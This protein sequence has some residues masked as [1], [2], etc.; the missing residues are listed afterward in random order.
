MNKILTAHPSFQEMAIEISETNT[1]ISETNIDFGNFKDGWPEIFIQDVSN[2]IEGKS[3]TYL[4]D[5][6]SQ[7]K[8]FSNI[9]AIQAISW[10]YAERA[11]I[12]L[13]FFPVGTMERVDKEWQIATAK[14][15]LR[16][17]GATP[18]AIWGKCI[19]HFIDIHD[20]HERF[21]SSDTVAIKLH[22]AMDLLKES[23]KDKENIAIAFPDEGAKKRFAKDFQDFEIIECTKERQW[24]K[25][26]VCI[27]DGD[28]EWRNV[29]I[30][31]DLIQSWGT[32]IEC[33]SELRKQWANSVSAYAT[34][35]V[36]PENSH[37]KLASE[38]DQLIV[39]NT[40]PEQTEKL[41][42][43]DN[44]VVLN[45]KSIVEK[46]IKKEK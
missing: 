39:T 22:S 40:I 38:L 20:L 36:C 11:N 33:S 10:Y 3:V 45:I 1:E 27:K 18:A 4:W 30:V 34:H 32:I 19:F 31:D 43:I 13:P 21:Y 23:L 29:I 12:I 26:V 16:I 44:I 2:T 35:A 15:L 41:Q 8:L 28:V 24:N 17:L 25:R 7:D 46:I 37:V 42:S 5:I 9:A 6:S 14:T